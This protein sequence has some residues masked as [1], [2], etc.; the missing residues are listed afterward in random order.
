MRCLH[1]STR[2]SARRVVGALAA[3]VLLL[4]TVPLV[5]TENPQAEE[6]I[7]RA[8]AASIDSRVGP[9]AH[10]TVTSIQDVRMVATDAP[11]VAEPDY[12]ARAGQ[13]SRFALYTA[14]HVRVG[15]VMATVVV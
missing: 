6:P 1:K 2:S 12:S 9:T 7:R 15:V 13:S 5:A 11:L 14:G 4:W 8:I 3:A 10:A